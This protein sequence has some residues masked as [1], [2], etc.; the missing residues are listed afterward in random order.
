[1]QRDVPLEDAIACCN[2]IE[3]C[4]ELWDDPDG[5]QDHLTTGAER[6]IGGYVGLFGASRLDTRGQVAV[7]E[8]RL[9]PTSGEALE[10]SFAEYVRDGA[11]GLMPEI[12]LVMPVLF[13]ERRLAYRPTDV[14][15]RKQW[16]GSGYYQR[17]LRDHN[18]AH[19]LSAV[20]VAPDGLIVGMSLMRE[21]GGNDF[22][23]RQEAVL[24]LLAR[25]VADRVGKRL[26]TRE[27]LGRHSLS[28]RLRETLDLLL[29]GASEKEIARRLRISPATAHEY[30]LAIYRR[31]DVH[32]RAKLMA[33]FLRRRPAPG[34]A[35]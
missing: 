19:S 27:Q 6:L 15:G 10:T 22:T 29:E 13:R 24:G 31:F 12:P 21:R 18:V 20:E 16:Y 30:V 8:A 7:H 4:T 28:P 9:A 17:Y 23:E 25:L 32:S 5:W 34:L 11:F 33:Y 14:I 35:R 3:E 2:L 26:A 1:M